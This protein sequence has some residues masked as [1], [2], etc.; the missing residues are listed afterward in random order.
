VTF[1][2]SYTGKHTV[3]YSGKLAKENGEF[4][5]KGGYKINKGKEATGTFSLLLVGNKAQAQKEINS[6]MTNAEITFVDF[7]ADIQPEAQEVVNG[8]G[9][10]ISKYPMIC[11]MVEGHTMCGNGKGC[12]GECVNAQLAGNRIANVVAAMQRAGCE[13]KFE[14]KGW[15]C[16]HPEVKAKKLVRIST[17]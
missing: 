2:K 3:T 16:K 5:V 13:N 9:S 17:F 4:V 8:I 6:V 7:K 10:I 14:S 11:V 1:I 12:E 15:G